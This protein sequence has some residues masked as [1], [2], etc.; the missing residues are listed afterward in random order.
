MYLTSID[1]RSHL[2]GA[3]RTPLWTHP[4]SLTTFFDGNMGKIVSAELCC[5]V[6]K[7]RHST[8]LGQIQPPV[9]AQWGVMLVEERCIEEMR[10]LGR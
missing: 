2:D 6:P 8:C 1:P 5:T 4:G 9:V 10:V 7:I 3:Q